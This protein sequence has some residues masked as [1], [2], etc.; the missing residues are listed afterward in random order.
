MVLLRNVQV[1]STG[2]EPED[3]PWINQ[4]NVV[5]TAES[6]SRFEGRFC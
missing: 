6:F 5:R 1:T 3:Q 2:Y 4:V